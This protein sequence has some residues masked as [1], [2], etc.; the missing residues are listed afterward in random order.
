[1]I[2]STCD[3]IGEGLDGYVLQFLS[4][5]LA[6]PAVAVTLYRCTKYAM[7]KQLAYGAVH[8]MCFDQTRANDRTRMS[9]SVICISRMS[10][11]IKPWLPG[12][13]VPTII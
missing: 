1:M 9:C 12:C 6:S 8:S 11:R 13:Y 2:V 3:G 7:S 4:K 5:L 10:H